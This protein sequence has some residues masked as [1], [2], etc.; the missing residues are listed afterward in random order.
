M[1]TF[2]AASVLFLMMRYL[3]VSG[4]KRKATNWIAGGI[5]DKPTKILQPLWT[6]FRPAP[7]A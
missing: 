7:M 1:R 6:W 3:G 2:S 4:K 5:M